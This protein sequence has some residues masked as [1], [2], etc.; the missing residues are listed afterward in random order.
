MVF[1]RETGFIL[2]HCTLP[3]TLLSI[4]APSTN[5]HHHKDRSLPRILDTSTPLSSSHR[6][7]VSTSSFPSHWRPF[8]FPHVLFTISFQHVKWF[9]KCVIILCSFSPLYLFFFSFHS[10]SGFPSAPIIPLHK[11]KHPLLPTT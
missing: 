8:S 5:M 1:L 10:R 9:N 4:N 7:A 11:H 3:F 2:A 6:P